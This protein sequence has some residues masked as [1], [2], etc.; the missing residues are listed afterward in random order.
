M[1]AKLGKL[2]MDI[3]RNKTCLK[4]G[5]TGECLRVNRPINLTMKTYIDI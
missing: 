3:K 2:E 4:H 5:V 1:I